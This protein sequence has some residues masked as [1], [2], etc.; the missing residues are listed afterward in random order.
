M[1]SLL[2]TLALCGTASMMSFAADQTFTGRISDS[3]WRE[4]CRNESPAW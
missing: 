3:V 2:L 4:P 1:K